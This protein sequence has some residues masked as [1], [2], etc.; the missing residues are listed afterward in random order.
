MTAKEKAEQDHISNLV[1][2]CRQ[3]HNKAHSHDISKEQLF[4]ITARR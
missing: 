3:C 1:A 4:E 2:L